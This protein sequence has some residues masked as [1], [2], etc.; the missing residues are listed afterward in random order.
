MVDGNMIKT[1][2]NIYLEIILKMSLTIMLKFSDKLTNFINIM[3]ITESN[4]GSASLNKIKEL[5]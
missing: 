3:I 5:N 4:L 2:I 1:I